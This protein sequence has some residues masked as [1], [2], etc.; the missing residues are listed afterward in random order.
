[1]NT[2]DYLSVVKTT[3]YECIFFICHINIKKEK[4]EMKKFVNNILYSL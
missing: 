1:M 3:N 4:E 2:L